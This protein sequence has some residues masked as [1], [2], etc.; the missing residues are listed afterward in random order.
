MMYYDIDPNIDVERVPVQN[1]Y[2]CAILWMR[3]SLNTIIV[4]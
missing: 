4:K 2:V 1:V 3:N